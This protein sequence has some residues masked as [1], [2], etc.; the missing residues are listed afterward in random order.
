MKSRRSQRSQLHERKFNADREEQQDD[1][2]FGQDFNRARVG[3]QVKPVGADQCSGHQKS[4]NR[5]EPELM[6]D[7]H[8]GNGHRE[9]DEQIAEDAVVGHTKG[10][11]D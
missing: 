7:K 4:R 5:R 11:Q 9:D 10:C 1:A 6:K 3:D 2:D 8:D